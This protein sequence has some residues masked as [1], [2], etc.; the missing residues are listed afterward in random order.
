MDLWNNILTKT[1][2]HYKGSLCT[3]SHSVINFFLYQE[4]FWLYDLKG[5]DIDCLFPKYVYLFL[6]IQW[7]IDVIVI[8][9]FQYKSPKLFE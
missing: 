5:I 8:M 2:T 1:L 6:Y 7:L 9:F 3:L 4:K